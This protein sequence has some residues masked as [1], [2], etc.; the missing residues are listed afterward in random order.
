MRWVLAVFLLLAATVASANGKMLHD[1][2]CI[3]CHATLMG[4][5]ANTIYQKINSR[6]TDMK[7]L[8]SQVEGCA[9][10]ADVAWLPEEHQQVVNYLAK[11]FYGF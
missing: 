2:A 4:G 8:D 7:R 3:Q 6:I 11:T 1:A 9:L 10:A 5:D